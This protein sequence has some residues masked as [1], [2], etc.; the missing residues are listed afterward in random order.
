VPFDA[1]QVQE[2]G[3]AC[4]AFDQRPD[5]RTAKTE[6]E[7]P[8]PMTRN[9][10]VANLGRSV[11]DHQSIGDEGLAAAPGAFTQQPDRAAGLE[12]GHPC[13]LASEELV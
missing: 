4:R 5:R 6:N 12:P 13:G 1:R 11:A 10:S 9:R 7:I 2:H 8:L 3:E